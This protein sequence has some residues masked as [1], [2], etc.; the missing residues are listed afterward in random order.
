MLTIKNNPIAHNASRHLSSNYNSL[1]QSVERLSSGQRINSA[2][3]DAAGLAVRELIRADTAV[4]LQAERNA[5]DGISLLQTMEGALSVMDE[6]LNR[7]SELAEQAATGSYSADQRSIMNAEFE[8]MADEIER[9]SNTHSLNGIS[10]L[11][12]ATGSVDIHVGTEDTININKVNLTSAGLGIAT[13][14]AGYKAVSDHGVANTTDNWLTVDDAGNGEDLDLSIQFLDSA[15][16][17]EEEIVVTFAGANGGQDFS[18][19]KV[20]EKINE[21]TLNLSVRGNGAIQSYSMASIYHDDATGENFL[22]LDS[23]TSLADDVNITVDTGGNTTAAG[24]IIIG[25]GANGTSIIE[26]PDNG[27]DNG[28]MVKSSG[29]GINI[30]EQQTAISALVAVRSAISKKDTARAELGYKMNR[31]ESTTSVLRIQSENLLAAE[32][33]ISDVDIAREVSRLTRNQVLTQGGISMLAQG[34][35]L[36]RMALSLLRKNQ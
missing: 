24:G 35:S 6:N 8:E 19:Q 10:M 28:K 25:A 1:S 36:P 29:T 9:I 7:M 27:A 16:S 4:L 30:L 33:R 22:Q 34:N 13:G 26:N 32:S 23:R 14:S 18:L 15:N 3:D 2:K 5:Q 20:V 31:L 17:N 12:T 11:N 21:V